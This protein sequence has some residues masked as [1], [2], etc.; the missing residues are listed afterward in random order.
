[1]IGAP[2]RVNAPR[3]PSAIIQSARR[4]SLGVPKCYAPVVLGIAGRGRAR[5]TG[6]FITKPSQSMVG[7][8]LLGLLAPEDYARLRPSLEYVTLEQGKAIAE[9]DAPMEAVVFPCSGVG[10][11]VVRTRTGPSVEVGLVGREGLIGVPLVL[12]VDSSPLQA[13]MQ[14]SGEGYAVNAAAF[15]AALKASVTLHQSMLRYVHTLMIQTAYTA[16][17]NSGFAIEERLA[18]WLLMCHDRV[19]GDELLITHEFLSLM[20][21]VRRPSVTVAMHMLEGEGLVRARR[22]RLTVLDRRGLEE[23]AGEIYGRPEREYE[24]LLGPLRLPA[25]PGDRS[26]DRQVIQFRVQ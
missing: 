23:F 18:R 20:L 1:M 9:V 2:E 3:V 6:A 12:G 8:S 26:V 22:A 10:S 15:T 16:I 14:I 17:T 11:L 24:R 19:D 21:A 5:R 4:L 25:G 13:F 7:N